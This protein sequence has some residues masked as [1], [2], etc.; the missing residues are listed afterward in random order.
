[1]FFFCFCFSSQVHFSRS[2]LL[3]DEWDENKTG[4]NRAVITRLQKSR[5]KKADLAG[6]V[7][8]GHLKITAMKAQATGS[9]IGIAADVAEQRHLQV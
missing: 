9:N 6:C 3:E 5:D 4:V 2:F 1:M 7:L 8:T